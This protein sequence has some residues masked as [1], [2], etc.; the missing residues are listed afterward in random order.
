MIHDEW[1][2][3]H[4]RL[5]APVFAAMAILMLSA[6]AGKIGVKDEQFFDK[7]KTKVED[8]RPTAPEA[9]K[10]VVDLPERQTEGEQSQEDTALKKKQR[11]LPTQKVTLDMRKTRIDTVLRALSR[12]AGVNIMLNSRVQGKV[13]ISVNETPW[14]QVFTGLL[15]TNGLEYEWLGNIIRV[16]SL[17]DMKHEQQM[18]ATKRARIKA[19]QER[20][21]VESL[22]MRI[23]KL[24]YADAKTMK[25][26]IKELLTKNLNKNGGQDDSRGSVTV[27][28]ENNA[29]VI[30][31]IA[32]D[33]AKIITL[34]EK[35]DRPVQQVLIEANIVETTRD[36]ARELGVQWGGLYRNTVNGNDYWFTP[37]LN[38]SG[39]LDSTLPTS[40]RVADPTSGMVADFPADLDDSGMSLG[41]LTGS[42][43][44]YIL[45]IQLSALE[46]DQ[47][48]NILSSP[49]ITTMD[50]QKAIIE[51]GARIP[52]QTVDED[53]DINTE[54]E[55][56]VLKLEVTPHVI[57]KRVLKLNILTK[58]DEVDFSRTV[59]GNP[60]IIKKRAE[61]N[62]ILHDGQTTVI[63]GLSKQTNTNSDRG[64]PWL[65]N[66]PGIGYLFKSISKSSK[67]E[68]ILIFITPHIIKD[69]KT[70]Q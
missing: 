32:D 22:L 57:N 7:W 12:S 34:V 6:C 20:K 17:E 9:R 5:L 67:M 63:G 38:S 15:A 28:E 13:D 14:N 61:T 19:S 56:A 30:H 50:N 41:F 8:S 70:K 69:Q 33:I 29:L 62:L 66:I 3:N 64:M 35:L 51:S 55:D 27:D 47:K 54:F 40:G 39:N 11:I 52:F 59:Q 2:S 49:S 25:P 46:E 65:K 36:I 44:E 24:D 48:L 10:R 18:E 45:N 53:G 58:K 43:D 31:A 1:P 60:T 68:D 42:L 26:A 4:N 16:I 21:A 37:G 23:I